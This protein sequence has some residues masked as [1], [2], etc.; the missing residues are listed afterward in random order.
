[1]AVT[2]KKITLWRTE[3]ENRPGVLAQVLEPLANAGTDL[4]AVMGYRYPGNES[5]AAIEVYPVA[6]RKS[7]A[8]ARAAELNATSIPTVLIEG[9]NKPGL[10]F[11]IARA[12]GD[13]GVNLGFMV[14][15]VIGRRYSAIIGFD[16][17][18]DARRAAP[19]IKKATA[20][21]KK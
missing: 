15:Q 2:V 16:N 11:A 6:G 7:V 14:A 19:L 10:G 12:L 18:E 3:V 5:K 20:G 21:K 17:E 9:D 13:A 8:A 1:M 4:Q